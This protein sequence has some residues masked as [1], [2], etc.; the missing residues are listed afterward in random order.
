MSPADPFLMCHLIAMKVFAYEERRASSESHVV[1]GQ[2]LLV[3]LLRE[4]QF[5]NKKKL[6]SYYVMLRSYP[7][8]VRPCQ[9]VLAIQIQSP[10]TA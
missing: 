10:Q 8:M 9:G 7:E 3:I 2:P 5:F 6:G 4:I 1:M